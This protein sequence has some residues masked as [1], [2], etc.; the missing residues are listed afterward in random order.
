MCKE[1][2]KTAIVRSILADHWDVASWHTLNLAHTNP[3]K[4][5]DRFGHSCVD[6]LVSH[7]GPKC[8][9]SPWSLCQPSEPRSTHS[10]C[11]CHSPAPPVTSWW[12]LR[13][14][15]DG[16]LCS[17]LCPLAQGRVFWGFAHEPTWVSFAAQ[18]LRLYLKW[19]CVTLVWPTGTW[20]LVRNRKAL[21]LPA[22]WWLAGSATSVFFHREGKWG[23]AADSDG[24]WSF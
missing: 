10:G 3:S 24:G 16:V 4:I 18:E 20:P 9:E 5:F 17:A 8:I 14:V 19:A 6:S 12:E 11:Q 13:E 23:G 15:I 7:S 1:N 21:S 22:V 2:C